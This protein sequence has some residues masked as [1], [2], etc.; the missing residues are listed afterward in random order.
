MLSLFPHSDCLIGDAV[1]LEP[2]SVEH[3]PGLII[4]ASDG[5]LWRLWFTSVPDADGMHA[6]VAKAIEEFT[7][8]VS[9]PFTVRD[10]ISGQILGCTRL[11]QID[12]THR[13][14]EI[15]YTWYAK[16]VQKTGVNT[17][18][19]LLLLNHAFTVLK[20]MAVEFR[21][22]WHNHVSRQA[23]ARLG[24]KQD[25]VLR[26]HK[27]LADGSIR[28]TVVFSIIESEWSCVKLAL[29]SKLSMYNQHI[30]L[31]Y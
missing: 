31:K 25:G 15:G 16:S 22:H 9:I 10:K 17:E 23:I 13:R 21:T 8:G 4:A 28:D 24:A 18:T 12:S 27:I 6:Y 29:V 30:N 5:E 19:K 20:V 14:A 2:L 1:V 3:I 7:L 26:N 11:C